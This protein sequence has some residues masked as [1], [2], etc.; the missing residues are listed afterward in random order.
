MTALW[1]GPIVGGGGGGPSSG[2]G[3]SRPARRAFTW[4]GPGMIGRSKI[5][6]IGF[7]V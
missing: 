3:T 4:T 5:G 6:T 2:G 7:G 1:P